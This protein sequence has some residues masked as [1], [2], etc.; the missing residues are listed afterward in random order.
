MGFYL[1]KSLRAGPFRF[2]LSKSGLGVS[3]GIPGFRI[4]TGPR[5]N[6][7]H[8]GAHGVYYRA[9]LPGGRPAPRK[10]ARPVPW[11][12]TAQGSDIAMEDVTGATAMELVATGADDL[13]EQLNA[14]ARRVPLLP[15][16]VIALIVLVAALPAVAALALA[17]LGTPAAVWLA[18]RDRARRSVVAFYEVDGDQAAWFEHLLTSINTLGSASGLWRVNAS[19]RVRTTH[20]YKINSGASQLISRSAARASS[21]GP[22]PL[23]TNIAVPTLSAGAQALHFLPDRILVRD[24]RRFAALRYDDVR[25][26]AEMQRFIESGRVPRDGQQ[27]DTTWQYVN[28]KGGPDRR[29]KNNRRLPVMLYGRMTLKSSSGLSWIVDCSRAPLAQQTVMSLSAAPSRVAV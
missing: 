23:V 26:D 28:V 1:R 29:F 24:G 15:F 5:G 4:G 22:K 16:A 27:V 20:Q 7:V 13:V 17:I 12:P 2:N 18:L 10:E 11:R 21:K 6:Y 19:G 14:A 3:A 8:V 9:T 25:A